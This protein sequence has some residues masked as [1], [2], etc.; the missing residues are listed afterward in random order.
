MI[1][2]LNVVLVA[3]FVAMLALKG[4]N[5]LKK[6]RARADADRTPAASTAVREAPSIPPPHVYYVHWMYFASEDPI[7][8]R[9]GILLDTVRAV[10]P[11]STF[12]LLRGGPE[13]FVQKLRE[14]PHAVVVGYGH[15]PALEGCRAAQTP[16]G[17]GKFILMT[18]RSNPWRY[19]GPDS[20]DKLRI[21]MLSECLDYKELRERHERLGP[22]SPLL[23]V[24]PETLSPMELA[25]MVEAGKA[26]A[27]V[28]GGDHGNAS[29]I[30]LEATSVRILQHFRKSPEI[31]RG[32]VLL[33]VSSLD[34]DYSDRVIEA[35]ETGIRRIDAS[36]ERRRI[37]DYY[38]MVP[39]PIE[40]K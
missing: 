22:D 14:D 23:R 25:A 1:K 36:G 34:K 17:Y 33:Y 32:D 16:L 9:N 37:F 38:G 30:A 35:Y 31:G 3:V 20:L 11:G 27:F 26:D 5:G 10:F 29:G 7:S 24:F 2:K 39:P 40:K 4:L 12:T 21:V 6:A 15:H 19:T 18:L 28:A 13:Q 8:N